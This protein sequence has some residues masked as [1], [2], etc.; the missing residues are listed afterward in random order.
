MKNLDDLRTLQYNYNNTTILTDWCSTSGI[1]ERDLRILFILDDLEQ[2]KSRV[3]GAPTIEI[4]VHYDIEL[5]VASSAFFNSYS[6][7]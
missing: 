2:N 4:I 1:K 7:K 3:S 5:T 6:D